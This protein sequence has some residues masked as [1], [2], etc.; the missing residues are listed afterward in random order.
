MALPHG[1][2]LTHGH[3]V[4]FS[5]KFFATVQY[6]VSPKNHLIDFGEVARLA[7]KEKPKIIVCGYTAYSRII[8]FKKFA[9]IAKRNKAILMADISHIAGLIAGKAH[10]SPFPYADVIMTTTHKTL[11]G[12]RGAMIFARNQYAEAINKAVFPGMQ[13]GPH[14]NNTAAM[15]I[16]FAENLQPNF[17]KYAQ[18]IIKNAKSLAESLKKLGL[19][20]I[21]G[22]TDNHLIL[23]DLTS[24]NVSG[25][26]AEKLLENVNIYSNRNTVP[27]DPRS[28]F[29]PSGIR[30]G[31]PALTTRGMKEKE[32][33][34]IGELI[35]KIILNPKSKKIKKEVRTEVNKLTKKFPLYKT[36]H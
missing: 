31:T 18:Q 13:G 19:I 9:A 7:K 15:A 2:H 22:G 10:P 1:G 23:I 27:Y 14:D 21:T 16:A 20:L 30:I 36:R 26:E 6:H 8:N 28:P 32:M 33:K 4:S 11:R 12:P 24:T 35:A 34:I 5:G 17:K 25:K 3:R 29:D